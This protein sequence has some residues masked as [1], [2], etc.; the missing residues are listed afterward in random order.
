LNLPRASFQAGQKGRK[1]SE[2]A[3]ENQDTIKDAE[4]PTIPACITMESTNGAYEEEAAAAVVEGLYLVAHASASERPMSS[5]AMSVGT[6][7]VI[8]AAQTPLPLSP[9]G[10]LDVSP[11]PVA[12]A[13]VGGVSN[14][15]TVADVRHTF[16][17][18]ISPTSTYAPNDDFCS[19]SPSQGLSL[20]VLEGGEEECKKEEREDAAVML[21]LPPTITR[22]LAAQDDPVLSSNFDFIDDDSTDDNVCA[23]CLSGYGECAFGGGAAM[24]YREI[25]LVPVVLYHQNR[26]RQNSDIVQTLFP[27]VS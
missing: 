3:G 1:S 15:Q 16:A 11:S 19:L 6:P 4:E 25:S 27:L 26:G 12:N 21:P 20:P 18:V 13:A 9:G 24:P 7:D 23:I 2:E 17:S 14:T 5:S 10:F 8:K 22:N